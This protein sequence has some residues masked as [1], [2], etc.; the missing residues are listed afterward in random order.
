MIINNLTGRKW[1]SL[2]VLTIIGTVLFTLA[3]QLL[4]DTIPRV[5]VDQ[6][7]YSMFFIF[8]ITL[9]LAYTSARIG[10]MVSVHPRKQI[11]T[12]LAN[13]L[14]FLSNRASATAENLSLHSQNLKEYATIPAVERGNALVRRAH[15][16][17][18]KM[19]D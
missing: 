8:C 16:M 15:E 4:E 6:H 10:I 3:L 12:L 13:F 11:A 17:R 1:L 5:I 7:I 14:S 18:A 9:I 19:I 2:I